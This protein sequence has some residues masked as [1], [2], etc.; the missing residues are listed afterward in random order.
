MSNLKLLEQNS[1]EKSKKKRIIFNNIFPK[2]TEG[3]EHWL[4]SRIK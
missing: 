4:S 3:Y 2:P 1:I